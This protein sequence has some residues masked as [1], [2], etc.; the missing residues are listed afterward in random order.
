MWEFDIVNHETDEHRIIFG[1]S[2]AD[3]F[4][5]NPNYDTSE[6]TCIN[7]EYID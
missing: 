1:Y 7:S 6:W 4:R 5:R 3:A 2:L